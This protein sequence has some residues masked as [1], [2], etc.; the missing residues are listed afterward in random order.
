MC[1]KSV[2]TQH[3]AHFPDPWAT[4]VRV[5]DRPPEPTSFQGE[6]DRVKLCQHTN[7]SLCSLSGLFLKATPTISLIPIRHT[8]LSEGSSGSTSSLVRMTRKEAST[9]P[10][11]HG[12]E[13]TASCAVTWIRHLWR[14]PNKTRKHSTTREHV[15]GAQRCLKKPQVPQELEL[16]VFPAEHRERGA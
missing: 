7:C 14:R 12:R 5:T 16:A 4:S 11:S 9:T 13:N 6:P 2:T 15:F 8:S 10:V 3:T 1:N